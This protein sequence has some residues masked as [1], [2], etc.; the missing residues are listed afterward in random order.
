MRNV[1]GAGVN[2][3][4]NQFDTELERIIEQQRLRVILYKH[5]KGTG[6]HGGNKGKGRVVLYIRD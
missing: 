1:I 6:R 5:L 4:F 3:H 2:S